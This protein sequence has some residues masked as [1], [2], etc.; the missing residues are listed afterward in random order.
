MRSMRFVSVGECI[1]E[2]AGS[3]AT[4]YQFGLAGQ[5]LDMALLM[6]GQLGA[7]WTVDLFTSLGDDYYSQRIID[8]LASSGVGIGS[9]LKVD[10][11][12]VGLTVR[13]AAE[14][15]GVTSWRSHSAARWM[16][17]DTQLLA[18]AFAGS[19]LIFVS[20]AAFAILVPR[21]RGRLMKALHRARASGAR[22]ALAPHEW[23]E[24]WTSPRVMGSAI[25][26]ISMVADIILTDLSSEIALYGDTTPQAVADR[27]R[28]WSVEEVFVR[29][30]R[31][32]AFVGGATPIG[33]F[34]L[35]TQAQTDGVGAAYLTA[36]ANTVSVAEAATSISHRG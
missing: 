12:N 4:G 1:V 23:P 19:D 2:L 34:V 8:K 35:N 6:R 5:A 9:I 25:N 28:E 21:A 36:R 30:S 16:A 33:P 31:E 14:D 10:G 7:D 26:A 32:Q 22:I 13:D 17:D 27:Y 20:G 15:G 29:L 11:R 24:L 18:T 3:A